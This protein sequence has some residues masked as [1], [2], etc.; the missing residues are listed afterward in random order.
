MKG[1]KMKK[2][3]VLILMLLANFVSASYIEVELLGT[4]SFIVEALEINGEADYVLTTFDFKVSSFEGDAFIKQ[5]EK[6][7]LC[8][9]QHITPTQA[10]GSTLDLYGSGEENGF[11]E[12]VIQEGDSIS[13]RWNL[14]LRPLNTGFVGVEMLGLMWSDTPGGV[15]VSFHMDE[16][17]ESPYVY[18]RATIPEPNIFWIFGGILFILLVI[19]LIAYGKKRNSFQDPFDSSV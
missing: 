5:G 7:V 19:R 10:L 1:E 9:I 14:L 15:A 6:V 12:F 2:V 18:A 4:D 17:F 13:F 3:F 8:T 11:G 16:G